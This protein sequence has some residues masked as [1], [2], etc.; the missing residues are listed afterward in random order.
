M[1]EEMDAVGLLRAAARLVAKALAKIE[2]SHHACAGCGVL[3][4]DDPEQGRIAEKLK[5]TPGKLARI[6]NQLSKV[7][8][9]AAN[10]RDID[11]HRR[12]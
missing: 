12:P 4:F 5:E 1:N 6:A 7:N 3:V 10:R 11:A 9:D 8:T 2:T